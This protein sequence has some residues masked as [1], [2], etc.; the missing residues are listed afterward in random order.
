M[1]EAFPDNA[2]T[3]YLLRDRDQIYRREFRVRIRSLNIEEILCAPTRPSQRSY[4]ERLMGSVRR[5]CLDHVIVLGEGHLRVILKSYSTII[6]AAELTSGSPR[7]RWTPGRF[8]PQHWGPSSNFLSSEVS[9]TAT[10]GA[11]RR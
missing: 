1:I 10:N 7:T 8:N 2:G 3:C 11:L 6:T 5:D 4:V 9:I